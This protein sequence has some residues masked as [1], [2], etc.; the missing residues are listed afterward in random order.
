MSGHNKKEVD[1]PW[2]FLSTLFS[3]CVFFF[4]SYS[5]FSSGS[6]T[7]IGK[8]EITADNDPFLFYLGVFLLFSLGTAIV[9]RYIYLKYMAFKKSVV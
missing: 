6:T 4:F 5:I 3:S 9:C 1:E 2:L 8:R 7:I